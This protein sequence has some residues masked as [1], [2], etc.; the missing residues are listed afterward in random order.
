VSWHPALDAA[1]RAYD[2]MATS[3]DEERLASEMAP[4]VAMVRER[5]PAVTPRSDDAPRWSGY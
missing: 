2:G 4:F 5:L 3:E 1:G